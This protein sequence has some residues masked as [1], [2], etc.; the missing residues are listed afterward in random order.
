MEKKNT[1]VCEYYKQVQ[2]QI[3]NTNFTGKTP[4]DF[5]FSS[6]FLFLP[7]SLSP[8]CGASDSFGSGSL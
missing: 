6:L 3:A 8:F 1:P 5:I 7:F 2:C 4:L